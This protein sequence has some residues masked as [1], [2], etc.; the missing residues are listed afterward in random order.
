VDGDPYFITSNLP[1]TNLLKVK[2]DPVYENTKPVFSVKSLSITNK[3]LLPQI[4]IYCFPLIAYFKISEEVPIELTTK[5][6]KEI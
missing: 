1:S 3:N 5:K 4:L 2:S 6:S